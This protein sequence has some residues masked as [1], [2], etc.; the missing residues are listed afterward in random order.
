MA[1]KGGCWNLG[2]LKCHRTQNPQSRK[3]KSLKFQFRDIQKL[4]LCLFLSQ[5]NQILHTVS[6]ILIVYF[7]PVRK[8]TRMT[9]RS[10][11]HLGTP[12]LSPRARIWE[13]N[14]LNRKRVKM[15]GRKLLMLYISTDF[16]QNTTKLQVKW[17]FYLT[18]FCSMFALQ[19]G[20]HFNR[21][22]HKSYQHWGSSFFIFSTAG[23]TLWKLWTVET[24]LVTG[25]NLLCMQCVPLK[26]TCKEKK[27]SRRWPWR[28]RNWD[29]AITG[30]WKWLFTLPLN[31]LK[32]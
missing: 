14:H 31:N 3:K 32:K 13:L 27:L 7:L 22:V 21:S 12:R 18:S 15:G 4:N 1:S 9:F 10:N 28:G 2:S 20:V 30:S 8:A 6:A 5:K 26:Y 16:K 17:K 11:C 25:K 24:A 19:L 23:Q 29:V